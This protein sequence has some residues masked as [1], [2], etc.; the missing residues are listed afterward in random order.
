MKY[1]SN[2]AERRVI[3]RLGVHGL[4]VGT[5]WSYRDVWFESGFFIAACAWLA[6]DPVVLDRRSTL[7]TGAHAFVLTVVR[8]NRLNGTCR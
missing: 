5:E 7:V 3:V 6:N 2:L 1:G 8:I 4:I